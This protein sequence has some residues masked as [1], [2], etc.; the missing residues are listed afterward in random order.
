MLFLAAAIAL[1]IGQT[2]PVSP[3]TLTALAD[4]VEQPVELGQVKW[5]RDFDAGLAE[6]KRT[7]K[8]V[9]LLFQEVPG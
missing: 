9:L 3:P 1:Q 6:S 7:G 5:R 8:P 2:V 4:R